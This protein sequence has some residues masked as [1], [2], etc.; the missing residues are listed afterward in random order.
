MIYL[1]EKKTIV[2]QT[3]FIFQHSNNIFVLIL[4]G[5]QKFLVHEKKKVYLK[6]THLVK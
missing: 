2:Y 3:N 5:S 6:K 1:L 4:A